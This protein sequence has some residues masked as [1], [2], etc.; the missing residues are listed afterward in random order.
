[1]FY[2]YVDAFKVTM[3]KNKYFKLI[4]R[5]QTF[6]SLVDLSSS[7][8]IHQK[9]LNFLNSVERKNISVYTFSI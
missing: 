8:D 9:L 6:D 7:Y 4:K 2:I 1:M 3:I 5:Y